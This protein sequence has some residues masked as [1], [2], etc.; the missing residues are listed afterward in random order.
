MNL[1]FEVGSIQSDSTYHPTLSEAVVI[2]RQRF[3][4]RGL[5]VIDHHAATGRI[6]MWVRMDNKLIGATRRGK[7]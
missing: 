5:A 2:A 7:Q 4:E 6:E 1:R 3:D